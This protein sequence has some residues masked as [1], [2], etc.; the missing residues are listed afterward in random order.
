MLRFVFLLLVLSLSGGLSGQNVVLTK[1]SDIVVIRGKSYYLHTVQPGQTL[2]SICK[3]YGVTVDEIKALND[4]KDNNLSLYEV[5]KV[6][7]TEPFVQQDK[8]FY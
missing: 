1:S 6:P 8:Q 5:L 4:K 2:F 7:Y 3:A